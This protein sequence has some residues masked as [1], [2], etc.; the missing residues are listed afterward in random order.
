MVYTLHFHSTKCAEEVVCTSVY[1]VY[2]E[3]CYVLVYLHLTLFPKRTIVKCLTCNLSR[4][5]FIHSTASGIG[6]M[7]AQG[8]TSFITHLSPT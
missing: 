1:R 3:R 5:S 2:F 8:R 6:S 4:L 7:D